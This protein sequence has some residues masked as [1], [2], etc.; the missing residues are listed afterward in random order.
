MWIDLAALAVGGEEISKSPNAVREIHL[1][2]ESKIL[3]HLAGRPPES[4]GFVSHA[5][6]FDAYFANAESVAHFPHQRFDRLRLAA[7]EIDRVVPVVPLKQ[8]AEGVDCIVNVHRID[9]VL[10]A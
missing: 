2:F 7:R 9:Q 4:I 3:S 8:P 10:A 1:R 5:F 6:L